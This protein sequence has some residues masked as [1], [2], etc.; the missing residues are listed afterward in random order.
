M[1]KR[2]DD[3]IILKYVEER[4][5]EFHEARLKSIQSISLEK[6]LS[7]KN[8][9]LLRAKGLETPAALVG[10]VLAAHLSSQEETLL[11]NF[12]E[13]LAIYLCNF[14]HRSGQKSTARGIDLQ[15][16]SNGRLYLVAIKS[17]PNWGNSSQ[18][19]QMVEN[20]KTAGRIYRQS[21]GAL[22]MEFINGCCYGRSTDKGQEKGSYRKLCGQKFWEFITGDRELYK[23]IIE[24][25]GHRARERNLH[26][27]GR[28]EEVV[29]GFARQF[30]E[31]FC[32]DGV[33]SWEALAE[34]VSGS[35]DEV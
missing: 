6:V 21:K 3:Q 30:R 7:R 31:R 24:P 25:I 2:I 18:I 9:Y 35:R 34:F 11:G 17:G 4:L 26:F 23:R 1:G 16:Q 22:P 13:G 19:S 32:K 12:L 15:F 29:E 28:Y 27:Q 5:P 10:A 14:V 8:P 20:F 33:I